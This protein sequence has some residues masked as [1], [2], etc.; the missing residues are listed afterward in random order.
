[1]GTLGAI[2]EAADH[3]VH[4][5]QHRLEEDVEQ[6]YV[7]RDQRDQHHRLDGQGER[8]E[9]VRAAATLTL[10][11]VPAGKHQQRHQPGG[12]QRQHHRDTVHTE[13]V[14]RPESRYPGMGFDE[15][16]RGGDR[17]G[18]ELGGDHHRDRQRHQTHQQ[19]GPLRQSCRGSR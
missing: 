15:L 7:Q 10:T 5:D 11:V 2:A 14:A 19:A 9:G 8:G 13:R 1:L 6:Q 4:R 12:Q 16:I 17:G 3:E 18:V